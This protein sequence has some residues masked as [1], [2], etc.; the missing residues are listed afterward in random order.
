[1]TFWIGSDT[2]TFGTGKY[3]MLDQSYQVYKTISATNDLDG[4][5][6]EF[7][8]TENGTA[9]MTVYKGTTADLTAFGIASQGW[10]YDSIFQEID[11]ETGELLFEWRA[12]EHYRIEDTFHTIEAEARRPD[13]SDRTDSAIGMESKSAWDF[14]H[15]NSVDKDTQGNYYIS[16]RYMHSITCIS[17]S[18][19]IVWIL[20]GK[21]N[22]FT[23]LSNGAATNFKFQHHARVHENNI[24]TIFDNGKYDARSDNAEYSRGLL[25]RLDLANMTATVLQE[26]V[27]PD[28]VLVGSQ[29][30]VQ[31]LPDSRH[32]VVGWGYVPAFT[33]FDTDGSVLC[34]V[35]IAPS[36]VW[37]LG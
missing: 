13:S 16:S 29:G 26:Y 28:R 30:S 2:G 4:D 18:G 31:L 22:Q 32:A 11:I 5:L 15:I 25:V 9:L 33:E 20:G 35:H 3:V 12:S 19:E 8:I 24:L 23:D 10:I 34:D 36:I 1:L 14:F 6:H 27:H 21:Q 17:P 7:K 37:N